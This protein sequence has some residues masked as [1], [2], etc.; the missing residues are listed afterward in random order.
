MLH[1]AA[2][3][4]YSWWWA[5]HIRTKQSKWLE[6]NLQDMEEKISSMLKIIENN[7]DSFT[8][9]VEM[10]YRKRPELVNHVQESYRSYR[11]LAER[12]DHLSKEMQ[13]ANRTIA[14]VFPEQVQYS[15]EDDDEFTLNS[16]TASTTPPDLENLPNVPKQ[17][18]PKKA[19]SAAT[20]KN[21]TKP[22][23][24]S[25]EPPSPGLNE[26]RDE[27]LKIQK[28][29]LALQTEREFLQSICKRCNEKSSGIE[30]QITE[31]QVK[32]SRLQDK[33]GVLN[34]ID[35]D[36]ARSLMASTAL[37][38]CQDAFSMLQEKQEQSA[39]KIQ[40]ENQR[41]KDIINKFTSLRGEVLFSQRDAELSIDEQETETE[42]TDQH[43]EALLREKLE[44][45]SR[46]SNTVMQLA[47]RINELVEMVV[48]LETAVSSQ[49]AQINV[50]RSE[51]DELQQHVKTLE[52]EKEIL[53]ENAEKTSIKMK[54]L[55]EE[56]MRVKSL[57]QSVKDQNE[58]LQTHFTEARCNIDHLSEKLQNVNTDEEIKNE[59]QKVT[60]DGDY[61]NS[62]RSCIQNEKD[63]MLQ[64]HQEQQKEKE[65]KDFAI[66]SINP[67]N[68]L[69]EQQTDD[70]EE[71]DQQKRQEDNEKILS[72][73]YGLVVRN[74]KEVKQRL[75]DVEKKNRDGFFELALQIRELKNELTV[76]DK[77]IESLKKSSFLQTNKDQN[78]ET[79]ST[80]FK[81]LHPGGASPE[82][83]IH[84]A[85]THDSDHSTTPNSPQHQIFDHTQ[86]TESLGEFAATLSS[87]EK[88]EI[89]EI[90]RNTVSTIEDKFRTEIDELLEGN[91]EFWM[92]FSNSLNQIDKF[93]NSIK[94]LKAELKKLKG[95]A[96]QEGNDKH[97]WI[98]SE[99][100]AIY[101]H[102]GQIQ[103]ELK[104]WMENNTVFKD[105]IQ[106]KNASLFSIH[107]EIIKLSNP[108][109]IDEEP[110]LHRYQAAK[111]LGEILNMKQESDKVSD[112]LQ[113]GKSRIVLLKEEVEKI[114][115]KIDEELEMAASKQGARRSRVPLRSFLFGVKLKKQKSN[116]PSI[117]SRIQA[118]LQELHNESAPAGS[119]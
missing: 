73:E 92:R 105:E 94:D 72:D 22:P 87:S 27:I 17:N 91:L 36:E 107:E 44:E 19:S 79:S 119:K 78:H 54:E 109:S 96:E 20:I 57:S 9:R 35:D 42:N 62:N 11:A 64:N 83:L 50:L 30:Y 47:D 118:G 29:M 23:S 13:S 38:S 77:E 28:Q 68:E 6:E 53:K 12:Y 93:R 4:A 85:S 108:D 2:N 67:D 82:S 56:L 98:T 71:E 81:Y 90:I 70:D 37:K 110:G 84:T 58:N 86:S 104:L 25:A 116:K 69:K 16:S 3:N 34:V 40:A 45:D 10:Y 97:Q 31:M 101:K 59:E 63:T 33:F 41:V 113:A 7:G 5:S 80:E 106:S 112:E 8:Q 51:T 55:E 39:E 66:E 24:K 114:L 48:G 99:V 26:A 89:D 18:F 1:R 103:T 102:L 95:A 15:I 65:K 52:E 32:V 100:R 21:R 117:L 88:E 61:V 115:R 43:A 75:S 60:K 14:A 74:F 111:F 76:K 46:S 49:D